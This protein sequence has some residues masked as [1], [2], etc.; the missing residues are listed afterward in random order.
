MTSRNPNVKRGRGESPWDEVHSSA[1]PI[2][3]GIDWD[4]ERSQF[5]VTMYEPTVIVIVLPSHDQAFITQHS[6]VLSP[7]LLPDIFVVEKNISCS[8]IYIF[9][10]DLLSYLN[11]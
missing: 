11:G 6:R 9:V 2:N 10:G 5:V 1:P 4:T 7:V 8:G 3:T